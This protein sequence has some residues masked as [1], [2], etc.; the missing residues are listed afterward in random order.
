MYKL[1]LF[2]HRL[3]VSQC[4]EE[5]KSRVNLSFGP[6]GYDYR[7]GYD[8]FKDTARCSVIHEGGFFLEGKVSEIKRPVSVH[9]QFATNCKNRIFNKLFLLAIGMT[10]E[11]CQFI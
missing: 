2:R 10:L 3:K 6:S 4:T 11:T 1:C 9:V 8:Y 7:H 5:K